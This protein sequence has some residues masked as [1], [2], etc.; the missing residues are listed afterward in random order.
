MHAVLSLGCN[1]SN[2]LLSECFRT[3]C[4]TCKGAQ[5]KQKELKTVYF[6]LSVDFTE[7]EN[8]CQAGHVMQ[9]R[10]DS[11]DSEYLKIMDSFLSLG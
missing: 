11:L 6:P 3:A 7:T 8:I 1:H 2:R 4:G 10:D 5:T 9:Q